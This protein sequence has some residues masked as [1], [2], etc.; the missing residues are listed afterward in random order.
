MRALHLSKCSATLVSTA[1][2]AACGP[3]CGSS[4]GGTPSPSSSSAPEA[5]AASEPVVP[6]GRTPVAELAPPPLRHHQVLEIEQD[7]HP[8]DDYAIALDAW[9]GTNSP[10][11]LLEVR[12]WWMD[13]AKSNERSPFGKGV[14]RHID[15]EYAKK[16]ADAWTVTIVQG[17]KRFA[18]DVELLQD[19]GV[20]AFGEVVSPHGDTIDRCRITRASLVARKLVGLPVGLRGLDVSCTD[21]TGEA[22]TGQL[23]AR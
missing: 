3:S 17:R 14:R 21:D 1:L 16:A 20:A 6:R 12:M 18:F 23:V 4:P 9:I 10:K 15:I 8:N 2:V 13:T 7:F 5:A 19:G 11:E 22:R